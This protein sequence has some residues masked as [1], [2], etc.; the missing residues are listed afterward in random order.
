MIRIIGIRE[1]IF[2]HIPEIYDAVLSYVNDKGNIIEFCEYSYLRTYDDHIEVEVYDD[3]GLRAYVT[4][5]NIDFYRIE[6]E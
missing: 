3:G 2:K 6:I 4:I 1:E 5:S